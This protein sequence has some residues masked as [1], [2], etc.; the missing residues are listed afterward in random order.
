MDEDISRWI[1]EF[2]IREPIG[3]SLLNRLMS[4]L[5]LS[6]CHPRMKKTVLLR[7]IQSEISDGSVSENILEL[8]E[9]IEELDHEE[10]VSVL[11]SMKDAYCS[12][13]V[14]CTVK[15]L[16]GSGG[17]DGK[18]FD[19]V[20]RIW[21]GKIHQM[22]NSATA[23]LISDQLRKWRDDIE[24]AVW[25][26][27]VCEGILTMN[28]RNNALKMVRAFVAEAWAVMGPPFLEL[29]ARTIKLAEGLPAA[30]SDSTCNQDAASS[31]NVATDLAVADKDKGTSGWHCDI[32]CSP[33]PFGF[34]SF[35]FLLS[36]LFCY[37]ILRQ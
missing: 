1:L 10:G 4:I 23:G 34:L 15:F 20:K 16:V 22:E 30:S 24:A 28:T 36:L 32:V 29:A 33:P 37:V 3:D 17:K 14:E 2:I 26:A 19:A 8:I 21:R 5:P 11:D 13:A 31:P 7:K 18:Y 27:R 35:L 25:D 12:V 9:I 6:N